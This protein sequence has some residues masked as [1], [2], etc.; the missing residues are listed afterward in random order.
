MHSDELDKDKSAAA[1]VAPPSNEEEPVGEPIY[2]TEGQIAQIKDQVAANGNYESGGVVLRYP[3]GRT[4][5]VPLKNDLIGK[6]TRQA[7]YAYEL[8]DEEKQIIMEIVAKHPE[9]VLAWYHSGP[10]PGA[11]LSGGD[12]CHYQNPKQKPLFANAANIV[13]DTK[14]GVIKDQAAYRWNIPANRFTRA[15]LLMRQ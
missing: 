12:E 1:F 11:R 7:Q 8:V 5:V 15:P 13:F 2:L 6:N 9:M 4:Q 3:D 10:H 14:D